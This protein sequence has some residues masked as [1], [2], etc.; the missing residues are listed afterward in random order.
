MANKQPEV[1]LFAV[2]VERGRSVLWLLVDGRQFVAPTDA[3]TMARLAG[4]GVTIKNA[5]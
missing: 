2:G 3:V 4:L 1:K 5:P